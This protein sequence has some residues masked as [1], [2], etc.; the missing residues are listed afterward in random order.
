MKQTLRAAFH[1]IH[2]TLW[3]DAASHYQNSFT[4]VASLKKMAT[5][6]RTKTNC[7]TIVGLGLYLLSTAEHAA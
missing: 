3:I 1:V 2:L 4:G 6:R 7:A 5:T